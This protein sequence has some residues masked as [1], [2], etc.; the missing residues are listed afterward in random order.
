MKKIHMVDVVSE[1]Q[2]YSTEINNR[3]HNVLNSGVYIQGQEV[4]ELEKELSNYLNSK[5]TITCANG[6][7]ALCLALM[8]LNL[9]AGDEVLI[10]PFTFVSTIEAVCL[11]GLKPVFVDVDPNTFLLNPALIEA[12]I[13]NKTKVILPVHLFGQCC[14]M[15]SINIIHLSYNI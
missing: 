9:K 14:D 11:L 15:I 2:K 6:T 7:D 13:S 8:A 1:Y 5:Y 10:P 4:K 12:N 3:I